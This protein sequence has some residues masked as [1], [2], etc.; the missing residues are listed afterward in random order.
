M[1]ERMV[2]FCTCSYTR[3][4]DERTLAYVWEDSG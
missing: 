2:T 3:F 4:G 1:F